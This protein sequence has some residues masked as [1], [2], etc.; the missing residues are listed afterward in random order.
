MSK[1][2]NI[3]QV[4]STYELPD[5]TT[6]QS[7]VKSNESSTVNMTTS[8]IKNHASAKDFGEPN[9]EIEQTITLTNNSEY[10]ITDLQI[11]E[12]IDT[13]GSFKE[14]SLVIDS[15]SKPD[16]DITNGINLG[17]LSAGATKVI[18]YT[19]VID[20]T[21]T[22]ENVEAYSTLTYSVNEAT[23]LTEDT[24]ISSIAISNNAIT[25]TKTSDKSV[26]I[27]GDKIKFQNVIENKGNLTNTDVTFMDPIPVGTTFVVG[28][29]YVDGVQQAGSDPSVGFKIDDLTPNKSI[30]VTFEV[31]VD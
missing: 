18:K 11:E 23:D 26:V 16:E 27:K 19:L 8:F 20:E 29:V 13:G 2:T 17:T 10:S 4:T 9:A 6:K 15:E 7:D 25:I 28:S 22:V 12:M 1:I 31:T 14:G 21:P 3:S 30:T 5:Q 24:N